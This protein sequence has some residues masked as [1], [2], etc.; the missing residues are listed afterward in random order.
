VS[1]NALSKTKSSINCNLTPSQ[2]ITLARHLLQ[3]A[4]VILDERLDDAVV[5]LWIVGRNN[6]RLS[7]GLTKRR[8]G[9]RRR[10]KPATLAQA[11][12]EA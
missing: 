12:G 7:C 2:A 6:E 4:Q 3:K 11:E 5:Q 8:K 10:K 9:P 1:C